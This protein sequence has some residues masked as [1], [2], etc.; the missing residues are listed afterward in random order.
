MDFKLRRAL[1]G[2]SY[3]AARLE[4]GLDGASS[5][6]MQV[7]RSCSIPPVSFEELYEEADRAVE[8]IATARTH[9]D[10]T[11]EFFTNFY[12]QDDI[13][14]KSRPCQHDGVAGVASIFLRQRSGARSVGA[15]RTA[16]KFRNG[17][18]KYLLKKAM[19]RH[20]P[21]DHS[22]ASQE[23]LRHPACQVAARRWLRHGRRTRCSGV[24]GPVRSS[25]GGRSTAAPARTTA[26]SCSPS[27]S[28]Q[29]SLL[30]AMRECTTRSGLRWI[31]PPM[32][33]RR[34]PRRDPTGGS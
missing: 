8:P 30:A 17:Q 28:L 25:A 6:R 5:N 11:L 7:E 27:L 4:P 14:T 3:P 31:S 13:L 2:L 33:W 18:R 12:L 26:S 15:F 23:G 22:G 21:P 16:F 29:C 19:A 1:A 32:R 34:K 9:I 10:R 20:L 24:N